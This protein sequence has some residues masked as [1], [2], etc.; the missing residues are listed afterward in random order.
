MESRLEALEKR[1]KILS[2][3]VVVLVVGMFA[4]VSGWKIEAPARAED[5]VQLGT[6]TQ[7][8]AEGKIQE[9][10]TIRVKRIEVVSPEVEGYMLLSP[11]KVYICDKAATVRASMGILADC[12]SLILFDPKGNVAF[13]AP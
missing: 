2:G 8:I 1:V 10:D 3:L 9:F 6:G 12:P 4:L 5:K 7:P 11:N 13:S